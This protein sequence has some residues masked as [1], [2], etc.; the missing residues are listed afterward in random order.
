M[1][2]DDSNDPEARLEARLH[3]LTQEHADLGVA[4]DAIAEVLLKDPSLPR[5]T[6][7]TLAHVVSAIMLLSMA[8]T[9]NIQRRVDEIVA[10][11][12]G[13][14]VTVLNRE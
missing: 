8:S 10:E 5:E 2:D 11:I 13:Q 1:N 12:T 4:V 6:A 3:A 9:A 14:V 7:S